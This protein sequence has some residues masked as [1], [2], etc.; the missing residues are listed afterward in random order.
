MKPEEL[1]IGNWV[2]RSMPNHD[3]EI[4]RYTW[5]I[6]GGDLYAYSQHI[7]RPIPLNEEWL[8]KFGF[9]AIDNKAYINGKQ[10]IL[11]V[12]GHSLEKEIDRDGTWFD[13]IGTHSFEKDGSM[14]VSVLCRGNYVCDNIKEVHKLQNVLY[15]LSNGKELEI[16][17]TSSPGDCLVDN[18]SL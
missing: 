15:D 10:W 18:V 12:N 7:Y 14:S 1:R 2:K 13:G 5:Q 11:Q 16:K 9:T 17:K 3:L 8:I 4:D 6:T